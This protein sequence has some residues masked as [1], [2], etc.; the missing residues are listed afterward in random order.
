MFS[1]G[2]L[3]LSMLCLG[4]VLVSV[5]SAATPKGWQWTPAQAAQVIVAKN[6]TFTKKRGTVA[7]KCV[8]RGTGVAGRFSAFR[9]T[10]KVVTYS[11]NLP[12]PRFVVW[13]K[14]RPS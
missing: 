1:A 11:P 14:I 7:A 6:L 3:A 2:R 10:G 5:A 13:V 8:G 12:D 4:L 9:C